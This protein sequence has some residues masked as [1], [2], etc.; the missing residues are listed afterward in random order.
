MKR[1]LASLETEEKR[2]NIPV[3]PAVNTRNIIFA[4]HHFWTFNRYIIDH[5][6]FFVEMRKG[7]EK[8]P[9]RTKNY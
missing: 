3:Y 4:K 2:T 1:Q 7:L 5:L 9:G 6:R 8:S